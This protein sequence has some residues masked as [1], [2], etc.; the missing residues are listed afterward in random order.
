MKAL[1][2]L[3]ILLTPLLVRAD[4][5]IGEL[6]IPLMPGLSVED[7]SD[8]VFETSAGRVIVVMASGQVA[9]GE[10]RRYYASALPG[11]GWGAEADGAMVRDAERLEIETTESGGVL[12]VTFRLAPDN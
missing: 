5:W 2:A 8:T 7:D 11:L 6:D 4:G 3:V 9:P 1:L 10:V 12:T